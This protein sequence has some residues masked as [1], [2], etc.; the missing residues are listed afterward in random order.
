[1]LCIIYRYRYHYQDVN[2]KPPLAPVSNSKLAYLP[3]AESESVKLE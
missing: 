1:M 2:W 3:P